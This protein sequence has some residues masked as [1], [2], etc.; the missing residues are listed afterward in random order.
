MTGSRYLD[1]RGGGMPPAEGGESPSEVFQEFRFNSGEE[2][3]FS[4]DMLT[5]PFPKVH[6]KDIGKPIFLVFN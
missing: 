5:A 2:L 1:S 3:I 6:H 4:L